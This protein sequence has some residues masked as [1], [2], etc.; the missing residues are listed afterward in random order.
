[1]LSWASLGLHPKPI[2]LLN[3]AGYYDHLL[4]FVDESVRRG[5]TK[6]RVRELLLDDDDPAQLLDRVL[7]AGV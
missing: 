1:V 5:L 3:V 6:P 7:P 4:A 2:G